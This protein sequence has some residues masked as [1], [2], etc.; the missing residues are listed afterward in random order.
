MHYALSPAQQ[1]P[2]Q[3]TAPCNAGPAG[4]RLPP[5]FFVAL[6]LFDAIIGDA[7]GR[8]LPVLNIQGNVHV[9]DS[10]VRVP[11]SRSG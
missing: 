8:L 4:M 1:R 3:L 9:P 10:A 2:W 7:D 5:P 6:T 11:V